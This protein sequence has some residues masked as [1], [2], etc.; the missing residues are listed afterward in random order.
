MFYKHQSP[1]DRLSAWREVRQKHHSNIQEVLDEFAS[2]KPI[3]RYI[4]YYTP[5]SWPN[6]FDIVR[7]GYLCQSGI[8]LIL[9][10]TLVRKQFITSD[11]LK[12][13]VISNHTNGNDGLVL[14]YENQVYNFLSDK[15]VSVDEMKENSTQFGSHTVQVNQLFR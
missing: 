14:L 13:L 12:F 3:P 4:D 7:E 1:D 5:K 9:T 2:I 10:A 8:T 11:E 6:V 15:A